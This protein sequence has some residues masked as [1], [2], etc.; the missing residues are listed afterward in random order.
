ME[1]NNLELLLAKTQQEYIE[2]LENENQELGKFVIGSSWK[3]SSYH[4][5]KALREKMAEIKQR[6][7][8]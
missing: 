8:I 3:S 2:I 7:E 4:K 6:L 1:R 5:G